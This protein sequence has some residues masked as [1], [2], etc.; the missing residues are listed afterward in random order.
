MNPSSPRQ[1]RRVCIYKAF[2]PTDGHMVRDLLEADGIPVQMRGEQLSGLVGAI[3]IPDTW[4]SLWVL[5]H[6]EARARSLIAGME[7]P[8][9]AAWACSCGEQNDGNFGSCWSCSADRPN[10]W[11]QVKS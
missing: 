9:G 7:Q 11:E 2:G 10:L 8:T 6:N 5:D 3:P 4:P 1:S